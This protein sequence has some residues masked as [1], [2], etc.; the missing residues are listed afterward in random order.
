M[1]DQRTSARQPAPPAAPS[2]W[3]RLFGLR[4]PIPRWLTLAMGALFLLVIYGLWA[5]VTAGDYEERIIGYTTLPSPSETFDSFE[6]L[7]TERALMDNLFVTIRRVMLG[8][9]LAAVV[10]IPLG[11][12]CGCFPLLQAFFMPMMIFGRNIPL[13]ALIPLTFAAFGIAEKQ[14]VMFIFIACVMFITWDASVAVREV[15]QRYV[16]TAYTLGARTRHVIGKVLVPLA[17]PAVFNSLR[18][19]FGLAFGYIMLAEVVKFG[20]EAGGLGDIIR[21]SQRRG[22]NEHIWLILFIIPIVAVAIDR[23]LL[24]TQHSL[25]PYRYGG[26]GFLRQAMQTPMDMWDDMKTTFWRKRREAKK[27]HTQASE[28][29]RMGRNKTGAKVADKTGETDQGGEDA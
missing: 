7:W 11:I 24:W 1:S 26:S 18:L 21:Q 27:R 8:F 17:M 19:L 10:G 29:E 9:L 15:H 3:A 13:A 5:Y 2:L 25:F 22:M 20:S 6:E 23:C 4:K 16:D 12:F 28:D 14:K